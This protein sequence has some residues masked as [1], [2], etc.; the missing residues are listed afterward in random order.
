MKQSHIDTLKKNS[1]NPTLMQ[2]TLIELLTL[3]D[4]DNRLTFKELSEC[5]GEKPPLSID[6]SILYDIGIEYNYGEGGLEQSHTNALK[7]FKYLASKEYAEGYY[8]VGFYYYFESKYDESLISLSKY[9]CLEKKKGKLKEEAIEN[10]YKMIGQLYFRKKEYHKA[11][12]YFHTYFCQKSISAEDRISALA[13]LLRC[14]LETGT[15]DDSNWDV[16]REFIQE[17]AKIIQSNPIHFNIISPLINCPET[18]PHRAELIKFSVDILKGALLLRY[19]LANNEPALSMNSQEIQELSNQ[20][21]GW[22]THIAGTL[23]DGYNKENF[24]EQMTCLENKISQVREIE[25]ELEEAKEEGHLE[26]DI[27]NLADKLVAAHKNEP[28]AKKEL[29]EIKFAAHRKEV[30]R[31]YYVQR[32]FFNPSRTRK[33]ETESIAKQLQSTR[34]GSDETIPSVG[35]VPTRRIITAERSTIEASKDILGLGKKFLGRNQLG[36]IDQKK[37]YVKLNESTSIEYFQNP[38]KHP[39]HLGNFFI[40]IPGMN[41]ADYAE[42]FP[43]LQKITQS[44]LKTP[45]SSNEKKLA[46]HMLRYSKSGTFLSMEELEEMNTDVT[47]Q[48]LKALN[49]IFYHIFVKEIARR[50]PCDNDKFDFPS[51]I[52]TG[53]AIQLLKAGELTI[54]DVFSPDAPY[55]VVTGELLFKNHEK[56]IL[57]IKRVNR[58]YNQVFY[59]SASKLSRYFTQYPKAEVIASRK[60]LRKELQETYGGA[61]D[62]DG[63]GYSSSE[64]NSQRKTI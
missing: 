19:P 5:F 11:Q 26:R 53:R 14:D 61:S 59:Q 36:W 20:N 7:I 39:N 10:A 45:H 31:Q 40:T 56:V 17:N 55:G 37:E 4:A 54:K 50:M 44:T 27:D 34:L 38:G 43:F 29:A 30:D 32:Q 8:A 22:T 21:N 49:T 18:Y 48:D 9:I 2:S 28:E 25:L 46:S 58:L 35:E 3:T 47:E 1:A 33:S 13:F 23:L 6:P 42:I 41:S 57:K 64:D 62:T 16:A 52:I 12:D 60:Q 15:A 63:D 24:I 51:A